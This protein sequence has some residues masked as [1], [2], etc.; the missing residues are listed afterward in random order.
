MSHQ[1]D[2]PACMVVKDEKASFS[3]GYTNED[4]MLDPSYFIE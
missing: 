4:V 1:L 3:M 2:Y